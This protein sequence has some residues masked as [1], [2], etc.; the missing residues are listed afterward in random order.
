M[1]DEKP[2]FQHPQQQ[3]LPTGQSGRS[4]FA[5][6][7]TSAITAAGS[8]AAT[9]LLADGGTGIIA[10][11]GSGADTAVLPLASPGQTWQRGTI[12]RTILDIHRESLY[13]SIHYRTPSGSKRRCALSWFARWAAQAKLVEETR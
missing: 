7:G 3:Q 4:P 2:H 12:R 1:K 11:A 9:G 13:E 6:A 10:P 8:K 5:D